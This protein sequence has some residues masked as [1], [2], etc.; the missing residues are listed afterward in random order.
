VT[1]T[2]STIEARPTGSAALR[3]GRL[4][5]LV[6]IRAAAVAG[7]G[8]LLLLAVV[9]VNLAL[10]DFD[11]PVVKVVR[12]LFGGEAEQFQQA[13]VL[14]VRLPQTMV[15]VVVGA[16]LGLSGALTQTF[17]RNPL[18]SPDVLGVTEG[19]ALGAVAFIVLTGTAREST[20]S[21]LHMLGLSGAAFVG[22]ILTALLLFGLA[23]RHGIE[24]NRLVLIGIGLGAAFS[25]GTSWLLVTARLEDA[26]TAQVWLT[27]SLSSRGWDDAKPVIVT[28]LVLIPVTLV[29]VRTLNVLQLGDDSA[30]GLGVRLQGSQLVVL[31][32][33]VALAA[34]AVSAVGLLEFVAFVVPQVALRLMRGSRPPLVSSMIYG[35]VLVVAADLLTRTVLPFGLPAGLVTTAIG[36]PYLIWLLLRG[37]RKATI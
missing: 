1:A 6:P 31:T 36:G 13:I 32:C 29:L 14:D 25:A 24:G 10:G 4:S 18:A 11:V 23:W 27:G 16:A 35:A 21:P 17:A 2:P 37:K 3:L 19:A 34:V 7:L 9:A 22:G 8:L 5:W 15:A 28:L 33:A 26:A 12:I 30:R 20:S